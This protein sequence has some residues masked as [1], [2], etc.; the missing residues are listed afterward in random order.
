VPCLHAER[1]RGRRNSTESSTAVRPKSM[2][3]RV[4]EVSSPIALMELFPI[5]IQ[6]NKR[7]DSTCDTREQKFSTIA[8]VIRTQPFKSRDF[9]FEAKCCNRVPSG[10]QYKTKR[11][12]RSKCFLETKSGTSKV[13]KSN[14]RNCNRGEK[15]L[16]F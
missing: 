8:S 5:F 9:T 6:A 16:E 12:K 4:L 14:G 2:E 7:I 1:R 13:S 15:P 10:G 3:R 11:S